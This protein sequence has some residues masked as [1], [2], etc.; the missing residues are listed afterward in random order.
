MGREQWERSGTNLIWAVP[1]IVAF[2]EEA[3]E[4]WSNTVNSQP[5]S[6]LTTGR[7][8]WKLEWRSWSGEVGV[9]K[10]D[11]YRVCLRFW[12][13]DAEQPTGRLSGFGPVLYVSP[14]LVQ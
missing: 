3:G 4:R 1:A 9:E 10:V 14:C 2:D 11:V 13:R 6:E 12:Y 7:G 8:C 5:I